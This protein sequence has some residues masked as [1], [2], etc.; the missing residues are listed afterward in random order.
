MCGSAGNPEQY[1]VVQY[2]V[3]VLW[4][5]IGRMI[6]GLVS[7]R[8]FFWLPHWAFLSAVFIS[9]WNYYGRWGIKHRWIALAL[10]AYFIIY[11]HSK[12]GYA[13]GT[14]FEVALF[15]WGLMAIWDDHWPIVLLISFLGSFNRETILLLPLV[16]FLYSKTNE[17]RSKYII[18]AM[19]ALAVQ[20]GF[21]LWWP[22]AEMTPCANGLRQGLPLLINNLTN[23][24]GL[25][26]NLGFFGFLIPA[27]RRL[28]KAHWP[29]YVLAG[30]QVLIYLLAGNMP[31]VRLL[32]ATACLVV[33][34]AVLL[35]ET[36]S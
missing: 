12:S 2:A 30:A 8:L 20:I 17:M 29:L 27:L 36:K 11:A 15:A 26:F 19:V 35:D 31:E 10:A 24:P 32:L 28:P 13:S 22:Q 34:P 18:C 33:I 4:A 25:L 7:A 1:R 6:F 3:L 21:R 23:L 14:Y 16:G 5:W 9:L